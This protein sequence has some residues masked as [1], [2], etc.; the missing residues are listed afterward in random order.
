MPAHVTG[1][2]ESN[3]RELLDRENAD[4]RRSK[5]YRTMLMTIEFDSESEQLLAA[6]G[7]SLD[8]VPP[9]GDI[10]LLKSA[11]NWTA[12]GTT[13]DCTDRIHPDNAAMVV[14]ATDIIGLDIAGVDLL[15]PD[16]GQ[17][18]REVGGGICEV[19]Y[20]PGIL[21]HISAE[22]VG[23]RD[24]AGDMIDAI[25]RQPLQGRIPAMVVCATSGGDE[26]CAGIAGELWETWG[27]RAAC[28]TSRG[29][30]LGDWPVPAGPM[31]PQD[32][33][34]LAV[35]DPTVD[36][37]VLAASPRQ[38]LE[39]GLG[40]SRA[41]IA[42]VPDRDRNLQDPTGDVESIFRLAGATLLESTDPAYCARILVEATAGS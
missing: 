7:Y 12:G 4:P 33:C 11:A 1:D 6:R 28:H 5:S 35:C 24:V 9:A 8:T 31:E 25:Y 26:L 15:I 14:R 30:R 40:L 27:L 21:V 41:D 23:D 17:S 18:F 22:G 16:I 2:G 19:N 32:A 20:R 3:I 34:E 10:V 29:L 37:I 13:F 39:N 36:A 38:V 42:V